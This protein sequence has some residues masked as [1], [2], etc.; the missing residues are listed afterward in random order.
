MQIKTLGASGGLESIQGTSAFH[1]PPHTLIDAGTGVQRL[2]SH[3]IMSLT[4]VLL[5]HAHLDHIASLPL[6]IDRQFKMLAEQDRTLDIFALPEVLNMLKL[7]I[8]NE[9]IWP[10]FTKLPSH[11][12]PV[13]NLIPVTVW[14]SFTLS[15][16]TDNSLRVMPFP[17]FHVVP[18]CGYCIIKGTQKIA[19]C[20]DTGLCEETIVSLNRLGALKRLV[21]E[22]AYCDDLDT[23]ADAGHHLTPRRLSRLLASLNVLPDELVVTHLKPNLRDKITAELKRQLPRQLNWTLPT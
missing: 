3:E 14:E 15:S 9:H 22:C 6:L 23:L 8:F 4:N 19:I 13:I 12:F 20:G 10:D 5:T 2:S 1:L 21:I 16:Y 18:T 17:L 7:H 11:E